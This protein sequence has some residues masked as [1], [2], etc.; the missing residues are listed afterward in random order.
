MLRYGSLY[1]PGASDSAGR[2]RSASAGCRSSEPAQ[3][4]GRGS[5]STMRRRRP[6]PQ[7]RA[8]LPASTT[9]S[10]TIP[11]RSPSGFPSWPIVGAR[12][13]RHVPV[14]LGRLAAGD[15]A[16]SMMTRIRG[17]SNTKARRELGWEPSHSSWRTGFRGARI[18]RSHGRPGGR[19]REVGGMTMQRT[20]TRELRVAAADAVLDRLPHARQRRGSGGHRPGGV[21]P[22]PACAAPRA[23]RSSRPGHTCRRSSRG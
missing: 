15:V 23:S 3:A 8:A 14:W 13:P 5:T 10:T 22:L 20:R 18:R 19:P 4:S 2:Q 9:S 16:V 12:P 17:S 7:S 1:G 6:L 21:P 11:L